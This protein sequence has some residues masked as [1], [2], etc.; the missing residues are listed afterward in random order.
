MSYLALNLMLMV[1]WMFLSDGGIGGLLVGFAVGYLVLVLARPFVGGHS[2]VRALPGALWLLV[3]FAFELV[4]ASL[5]LAW[6]VL[7]PRPNFE[8]AF[9]RLEATDLSP[10]QTVLFSAL[11][12]LTPGSVAVDIDDSSDALYVH[13]LY[14]QD[15]ERAR[16]NMR[17]F[18]RL[19]RRASG[20]PVPGRRA[21]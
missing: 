1:V 18:A 2:Y 14:A 8:P 5:R 20:A 9:I 21:G 19:I 17:M 4:R 13:A 16:D 7:R 15:A 3:V 10:L 11:V 12:S 6:D